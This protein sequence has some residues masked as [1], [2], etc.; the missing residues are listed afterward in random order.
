MTHPR[1]IDAV[2]DGELSGVLGEKQASIAAGWWPL[3]AHVDLREG[4]LVPTWPEVESIRPRRGTEGLLRHFLA[5]R[6]GSDLAILRFARAYGLL[7]LSQLADPAAEPLA[8]MSQP[9]SLSDWRK[10]SRNAGTVVRQ[11]SIIRAGRPVLGQSGRPIDATFWLSD[12]IAH[13][14]DAANVRPYLVW[15]ENGPRVVLGSFTLLSEI[16]VRLLHAVAGGGKQLEFCPDCRAF[17]A[18]TRRSPAGIP[19]YCKSHR[20]KAAQAR[21]RARKRCLSSVADYPKA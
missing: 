19:F 13:W 6:D 1:P 18:V 17:Y 3:P 2:R 10:W 21:L 20:N 15:G 7:G 9:E 12:S 4:L 5:L 8:E 14:M 16:A 11:A